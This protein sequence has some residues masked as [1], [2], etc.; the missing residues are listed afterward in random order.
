MLG[1]LQALDNEVFNMI[2]IPMSLINNIELSS[3]GMG[4]VVLKYRSDSRGGVNASNSGI[5]FNVYFDTTDEFG[6]YIGDDIGIQMSSYRG[7]K[8][9][10][11]INK[12]IHYTKVVDKFNKW[13][14]DNEKFL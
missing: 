10:R 12:K 13:I 3:S 5:R 8:P 2:L 14:R 9:M 4:G 11:A 7:I 6:R 1:S